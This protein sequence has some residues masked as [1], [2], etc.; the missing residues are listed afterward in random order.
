MRACQRKELNALVSCTLRMIW[1]E[2]NSRVFDRVALMPVL[3]IQK[4]TEEFSMWKLA[5]ARV[6]VDVPR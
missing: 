4:I 3:V 5:R 2:R 6:E 1:L